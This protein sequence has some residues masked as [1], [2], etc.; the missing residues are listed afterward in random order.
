[1]IHD[2]STFVM[3]KPT[4]GVVH[5]LT[6]HRILP[7]NAYHS[8]SLVEGECGVRTKILF[9]IILIKAQKQTAKSKG[10]MRIKSLRKRQ[11]ISV[12]LMRKNG[13]TKKHRNQTKSK[14]R[15]NMSK[16]IRWRHIQLIV[17]KGSFR[18]YVILLEIFWFFSVYLGFVS[19]IFG[20]LVFFLSAFFWHSHF[21]WFSTYYPLGIIEIVDLFNTDNEI[22]IDVIPFKAWLSVRQSPKRHAHGVRDPYAK[23]NR[24]RIIGL[25]I[26]NTYISYKV[27]DSYTQFSFAIQICP[28]LQWREFRKKKNF[29][30]LIDLKT[31]FLIIF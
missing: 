23:I 16:T 12:W 22:Y 6:T 11:I 9:Q 31:P 8:T 2:M 7:T 19:V 18:F 20:T 29:G 26:S 25:N 5:F 28:I 14:K 3:Q 4:N 17:P 10:I 30:F 21:K 24:M 27:C 1:M 13:P 15:I